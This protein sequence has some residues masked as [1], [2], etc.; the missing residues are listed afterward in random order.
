MKNIKTYST[1]NDDRLNEGLFDLLKKAFNQMFAGLSEIY[2]QQ[3]QQVFKDCDS[4]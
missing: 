1:F 2:T 4:K 3:T